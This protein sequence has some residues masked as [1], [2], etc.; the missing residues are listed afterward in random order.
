M[1]QPPKANLKSTEKSEDHRAGQEPAWPNEGEGNK[2][3]DREY[4][5]GTEEFAKSGRVEE[6]ARKAAE[7]LDGAEGEELRKAEERGRKGKP[8]SESK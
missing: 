1:T 6:Q 8:R 7:A 4:R 5:K 2:T 3:A